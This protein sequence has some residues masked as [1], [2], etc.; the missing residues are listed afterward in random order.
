MSNMMPLNEKNRAEHLAYDIDLLFQNQ[1]SYAERSALEDRPLLALAEQ[2]SFQNPLAATI[3]E[4]KQMR[5]RFEQVKN[6]QKHRPAPAP[7]FRLLKPTA[8]AA[9]WTVLL[10]AVFTITLLLV[11]NLVERPA[12]PADNPAQTAPA[13]IAPLIM[14]TQVPLTPTSPASTPQVLFPRQRQVANGIPMELRNMVILGESL[15]ATLCYP[16]PSEG[17]WR[18]EGVTLQGGSELTLFYPSS[19]DQPKPGED[20][21]ICETFIATN[22]PSDSTEAQQWTIAVQRL[23]GPRQNLPVCTEVSRQITQ[24]I[25]GLTIRCSS[26][27]EGLSYSIDQVPSGMR[28]A[29]ASHLMQTYSE[30]DVRSGPWTFTVNPRDVAVEIADLGL[31]DPVV[32]PA[33]C[34]SASTLLEDPQFAVVLGFDNQPLPAGLSGGGKLQSGDFTFLISLACDPSFTRLES[35][36]SE[37]SFING[38]GVLFAIRYDGPPT[39]NSVEY[40]SGLWPFVMHQGGGGSLGSGEF[41]IGYEGLLL[42]DTV[43]PDLT[44]T[45]VKLRY[46]IRVRL[47]DGSING[48]ALAFTLKRTLTGYRPVNATVEPLLEEEKRNAELVSD[49]SEPLPFPTLAVPEKLVSAENQTVLDLLKRWQKPFLA[50]PGWVHMRTLT[51]MPGG[52]DLYAGLTEYASDDWYLVDEHSQVVASIHI[53]SR[54]DGTT[55]QQVVSQNGES[56]NLTFGG[57]GDFKSYLLDLAY[58]VNDTLRM[59]D[60]VK[61]AQ[62]TMDG[63]PALLLA[64]TGLYTRRD[65]VDLTSGAWI[66]TEVVSLQTGEDPLTGGTLESRTTLDVAERV[67]MPPADVMALLKEDFSGYTAPAPYGTPAPEG[68]DPSYSLLSLHSIQGDSF[69][70]PT[71]WYG[72]IYAVED[73]SGIE[74]LLGRVDFGSIPGGFCDRSASGARLAFNYTTTDRGGSFTNS[75]LRWFDLHSLDTIH[76]PAPDLV[77]LGMLSWSPRREELVVFGCKANQEGCGLYLL[78]PAVDQI[79]LLLAGVYTSWQP[80]WNPDGSQIAF[81]NTQHDNDT[82]YIVDISTGKVIYQGEFD[83]DAWQVAADS[84]TNTWGVTFP[85]GISGSRCFD[86]K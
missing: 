34:D 42:P 33:A 50:S 82:L 48:A 26:E 30:A 36:G 6:A 79:Q 54:I 59:G 3:Q 16:A 28:F 22:P 51:E 75:S 5:E 64:L 81:V 66:Y 4:R 8:Q 73:P 41:F 86:V 74:Y 38:L 52:S 61:H 37:R 46:P 13:Q 18:M 62:I 27:S 2:L 20:G 10:A 9:F 76:Q 19:G 23:V 49:P 44:Q 67:D 12:I 47:P 71:F 45:D 35:Y 68:F 11:S 58:P 1:L 17:D 40:F 78:D 24:D 29:E 57:G 60:K 32:V 80:I 25:P 70:A 14:Q 63:K 83:P 15:R 21:L 85:R 55:L 7:F 77:N 69:D 65:V 39:G 84:P 43:Q 56:I 53:D 72:D 31:T